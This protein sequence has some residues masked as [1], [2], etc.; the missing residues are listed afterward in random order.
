MTDTTVADPG[1][2][3]PAAA[4]EVPINPNPTTVPNPIGSQAPEK[5]VGDIEGSK[6]RPESRREAIQKA[7]DRASNPPPKTARPP[8]EAPRAAPKPAEAKPGH[9]KPPED[10]K[11]NLKQRPQEGDRPRGERGQFAPRQAA[12]TAAATLRTQTQAPSQAKAQAPPQTAQ[13]AQAQPRTLPPHAPF[14]APPVRMSERARRD[15]ADTP[16]TVRGDIHRIQSEFAKAYNYY[17]AD[18]EAMKPIKHFAKMAEEGGTTLE[19]ALTHYVGMEQ[20]LRADP[21]AGLDVIVNNLGLKDPQ[22]GQR[23]GLRDI[24]YYVLNQSPEQLRQVQQGNTQAAAQHQI[25][26]LHEEVKGL[27]E[28]LNQMHTQAQFTYTRSAVDQ[29]A[30]S[31]PR[32][33]E[34][35]DL[36]ENELKLGFDLEQAYQ[37]ASL[38]R[39]AAQ[40]AQTRTTPAQTRPTDKSISG[41]PDVTVSNTASKTRKPVGRREAIQNAISRVNGSL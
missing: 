27:K 9:N 17:K 38:L 12:E 15:W 22:T 5:P 19:R 30:D 35:G 3:P 10:E 39:P 16:E 32:F 8:Q 28:A 25:G 2:A 6:H 34:L 33:D 13:A 36:I 23:L 24:A 21:I 4:N 40:A 1:S 11:L 26:A 14:A 7:F 20:K 31:H 29:F 41:A 37:R 18:H